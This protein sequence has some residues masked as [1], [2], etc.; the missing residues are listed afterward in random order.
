[1]TE[2][3]TKIESKA[4]QRFIALAFI[5]FG[6]VAIAFLGIAIVMR[7]LIE[8]AGIVGTALI[9]A[10]AF[11]VLVLPVLLVRRWRTPPAP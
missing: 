6:G 1:M 3:E 11:G 8:P 7:R 10:G 2:E 5:R 4:R 9:A